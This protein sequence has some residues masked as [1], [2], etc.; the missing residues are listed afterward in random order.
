[1]DFHGANSWSEQA[2]IILAVVACS[3]GSQQAAI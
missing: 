1:M 2:A 3:C